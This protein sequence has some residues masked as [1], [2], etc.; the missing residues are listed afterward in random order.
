MASSQLIHTHFWLLR[1]E[2]QL[3][4]G[5]LG[6]SEKDDS[7][8]KNGI[9]CGLGCCGHY[10]ACYM[11]PFGWPALA[12]GC[13]WRASPELL[14]THFR[15]PEWSG[16]EGEGWGV[17]FLSDSGWTFICACDL[18]VCIYDYL[19]M[20]AYIKNTCPHTLTLKLDRRDLKDIN[21]VQL[22]CMSAL[23]QK[24][25]LNA[26]THM[27]NFPYSSLVHHCFPVENQDK[28]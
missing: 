16:T 15:R 5:P 27:S 21:T 26:D 28:D 18:N 20:H 22:I 24:L 10:V 23:C 7:E 9:R 12:L 4:I 25:A 14:S 19:C 8:L 11:L 3:Q 13:L 6:A 2:A 1:G 17:H